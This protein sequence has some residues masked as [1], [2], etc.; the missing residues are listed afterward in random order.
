MVAAVVSGKGVGYTAGVAHPLQR[1][2][3][4]VQHRH[5]LTGRE[6]YFR[7]VC[8]LLTPLFLFLYVGGYHV[9]PPDKFLVG[10][11]LKCYDFHTLCFLITLQNSE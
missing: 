2:L 11:T 1:A 10:G 4:D 9:Y 7:V 8:L 3:A 6:P 5:H